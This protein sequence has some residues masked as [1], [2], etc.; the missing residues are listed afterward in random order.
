MTS[1]EFKIFLYLII[2]FSAVFHE[3]MHAWM[4]F[5]L[6]DSTAKNAGRLTLNPLKHIDPLWTVVLPLLG[7]FF[8]GGFIG[9]AKPVPYNPYN[10]RDQKYG[11]VKVGFAGPA[12]NIAIAL[13]LG[14]IIRFFYFP[15]FAEIALTW[16]IFINIY[17]AFFNLL[18]I[19][20]LDGSHLLEIFWP[21]ARFLQGSQFWFIGILLAVGLAF[22]ILPPIA[23]FFYFLITGTQFL[24]ITF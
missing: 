1:L 23:S 13:F 14:L 21:R 19:P 15:G 6:G 10:L 18:P 11:G 3:Y 24:G 12:A 20:P 7:L 16:I 17:L 5:Y 9:A 4:A 8:F 22:L 2:V